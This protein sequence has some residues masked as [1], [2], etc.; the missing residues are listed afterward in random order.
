MTTPKDPQVEETEGWKDL[1]AWLDAELPE[2]EPKRSPSALA[3]MLDISQP[4]VRGWTL[5]LSRP[6]LGPLRDAVCRIIGSSP[7]RWETTKERDERAKFDK[8]APENTATDGAA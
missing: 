2:G 7:E 3:A 1:V 8:V 6:S 5:R 4:A